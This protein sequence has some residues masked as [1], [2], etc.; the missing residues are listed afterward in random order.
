MMIIG[1][2][3]WAVLLLFTISLSYGTVK[4]LFSGG[5]VTYST[6]LQA[7]SFIIILLLFLLNPKWNKL[8]ILWISPLLFFLTAFIVPWIILRSK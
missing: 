6:M 1:W 2:I 7:A 5:G 8:N 3:V 4:T